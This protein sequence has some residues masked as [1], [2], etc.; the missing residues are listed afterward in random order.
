MSREYFRHYKGGI[1]KIKSECTCE[2]TLETMIVY[3]SF[4]GTMWATPEARFFSKTKTG[5]KRFTP[6]GKEEWDALYSA[7]EI[8]HG[9]GIEREEA[10]INRPDYYDLSQ[11]DRLEELIATMPHFIGAAFK[12][13][14]RAGSKPGNPAIQDITKARECLDI[15]LEHGD[16][17]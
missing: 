13:L 14:L 6:V 10:A 8:E 15:H 7:D 12:Y 4:D 17:V 16:Y 9:P 1:Y 5:E 2:R 3:M 11:Y